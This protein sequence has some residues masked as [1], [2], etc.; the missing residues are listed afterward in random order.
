MRAAG[1]RCG[2]WG[3]CWVGGAAWGGAAAV[4]GAAAG[5]GGGHR[6][7]AAEVAWTDT[8]FG[9]MQALRWHPIAHGGALGPFHKASGIGRPSGRV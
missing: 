9:V 7:S 6:S 5:G 8:L 1:L 2:E 4:G 3:C